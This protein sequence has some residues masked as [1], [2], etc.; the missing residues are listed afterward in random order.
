MADP[1]ATVVGSGP[2]G[3]AAAVE[4]AR[5]GRK[6]LVIEGSSRIGGGTRTEE[7][8]L[9]GFRHDI[10]SAIHPSALA[11]P[12]FNDIGLDVDWIQPPIAF[13][14]PL[15]NGRV[16]ALHRSVT[17][18][19]SQFGEDAPRYQRL[20]SPLVE[21][22]EAVIDDFLAPMTLIPEHPASFARVAA[23]G[24]LP[25]SLLI[26][27]FESVEARSLLGG[28]S[29]HSIAPFSRP[30]TAGV[31]VLLGALGH[32]HGW[33]LARGGSV[34]ISDALAS[35]LE[36]LGGEIESGHFVQSLDELAGGLTLLDLMP[37]SALGLAGD[38]LSSASRA[39][40]RR[41][42]P[43]PGVFKIDWALD[44]PVPWS[45][46]LSGQSATVHIGGTYEEVRSAESTVA[47]GGHPDYPF[48]L[49]AQHSLFDDTR[50]P[51]GKHTL[52]GYC[53][54]PNG[55]DVDMTERIENQIERFAPGFRDLIL[56][57]ATRNALEYE[58]YN[59]NFIGGDIGG[60]VYGVRK[61]L[62]VGHERPYR[63][64]DDTYLCSSATPPGAGVHGMCGY[65]AA[66]A[67]L[68]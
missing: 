61:L 19:A 5:S 38:R 57:R 23:I 62:Q 3:L 17:E 8:T 18:T 27:R 20:M 39:R 4:I 14:H 43:G 67:A 64:G 56:E 51:E 11:S 32:S 55:S 40:L 48:V 13:T 30:T 42:R 28:L 34:A 46:S 58:A 65:Y 53:H 10:C 35:Q 25:A 1:D 63:I 2:N 15:G 29:A 26:S 7:L 59:P 66:R 37:P 9:P 6:V 45:D 60:G 22:I 31:A 52:W 54:V 47:R 41:W 68:V 16:A 21:N 36:L 49:L 33:P 44:G 50:A 12:F 24:A